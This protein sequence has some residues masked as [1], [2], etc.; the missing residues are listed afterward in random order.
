[1]MTA[2]RTTARILATAILIAGMARAQSPNPKEA[3]PAATA[4]KD[5]RLDPL[6]D[7]NGFFPFQPPDS[8]EAWQHRADWVR[9]RAQV[10]LGLWPLPTKTPLRAVIHGRITQP[11]YT[12]DKVFFE[13]LPGLF[14]T[15]NLYQPEQKSA[16]MPGVL[17]AHGHWKDARL[18]EQ[19]P[20]KLREEIASGAERFEDGGRSRFQS[21]CVQLARMGCVVW[22]W[23]MLGDSDSQQF[24]RELIHGFSKQRPEMNSAEAWGLFSP[25]AEARLQ[26]PMG[27]Q[28]WNAIRSMDFLLSLPDIDPQ[29]IAVTGSSGGG[30]QAMMLAA[31]DSRVQL[32]FPVVM[33]STAMQ[34]GCT[35]ENASLLRVDTGNVEFAALFAPKPQGMNTANDWTRDMAKIGFPELQKLYSTVGAPKNVLLHRGEHFPHNYNAVTRSAFYSFLNHHF[36]LG[37]PHPVIET[38][39]AFLPAEKLTVWDSEHPAPKPADPEFERRLLAWLDNDS[40]LQ[41]EGAAATPDSLRKFAGPAVEILIGR[42]LESAGSVRWQNLETIHRGTYAEERGVVNNTTHRESVPALWLKPLK[43]SGKSL[44]WI[45]DA[46]EESVFLLGGALRPELEK[47]LSLGVSIL[48]PD[49]FRRGNP[50]GETAGPASNR[51]VENRREFAG[52]TYGY[53]HS[54]FAQRTHDILSAFR[55]L[56]SGNTGAPRIYAAAL[57]SSGPLLAAARAI[58]P[59]ALAGTAIHSGGFRFSHLTDF[60]DSRFLPGAVKYWDLPG[61]LA[62]GAPSPLWLSGEPAVPEPLS[63]FD[64]TQRGKFTL[65]SGPAEAERA[66]DWILAQPGPEPQ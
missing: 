15:G 16:K 3:L 18:S 48:C 47:P 27:L 23:D 66:L 52:Y 43:P 57:G 37:A 28:T 32:S 33:V 19:P 29:R 45:G 41:M 51:M 64:A 9:R 7:L 40:K 42:T 6:K 11:G 21:L 39:Y 44:L 25:Q 58:A 2:P 53:N 24:S 14:V 22:Q 65:H 13:S 59:G 54:L 56:K 12:I 4:D 30:T 46:G 61:L 31:L 36:K 60:R 1:M 10:A 20:D 62:L 17:F 63:R 38:D 55:L 50:S 34:G 49:L 35:C 5:S 26:S 8:A